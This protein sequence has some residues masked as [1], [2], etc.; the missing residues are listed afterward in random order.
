MLGTIGAMALTQRLRSD[1]TVVSDIRLR[2]REGPRYRVCFQVAEDGAYRVALVDRDEAE[3]RILAE[4]A[5]LESDPPPGIEDERA[6]RKATASC[7][8]WNGRDG[9]GAPV[10]R[11][12]YRLS[13]T[14]LSDGLT[15]I[16]GE[17]LQVAELPPE[18]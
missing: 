7:F 11:G 3:V 12:A 6:R 17:K 1:G 16:S 4:D 8:D 10:P 2:T 18:P 5:R 14:R 9:A 13:L 15:L